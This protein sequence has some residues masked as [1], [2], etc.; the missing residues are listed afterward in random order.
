MSKSDLLS[1]VIRYSCTAFVD[2]NSGTCSFD[3]ADFV[4]LLEACNKQR[5]DKSDFPEEYYGSLLT[6]EPIQN[7][8]IITNFSAPPSDYNYVG[9]PVSSGSGSCFSFGMYMGIYA[10]SPHKEG[11]WEFIRSALKEDNQ[12]LATGFPVNEKVLENDLALALEGKLDTPT[13]S[14]IR[15]GKTDIAKLKT[16]IEGTTMLSSSN[17]TIDRI[18][19]DDAETYFAGEKTAEETAKLI[20]S[21]VTLFLEEQK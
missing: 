19:H 13:K 4:K 3:S 14:G 21:Q 17:E 8:G 20:Q 9:F 11:A 16:L 18:I 15:L 12:R 1:W 6:S 2:K 5:P 10:R 7:F